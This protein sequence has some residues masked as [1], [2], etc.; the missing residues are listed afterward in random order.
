[1]IRAFGGRWIGALLIAVSTLVAPVRPVLAATVVGRLAEPGVVWVSDPAAVHPIAAEMRNVG[2]T[3]V[4]S[5]VA[6]PVGST[7]RFPNDDP[8]FHSIY[9]ASEG[10]RVRHRLLSCG[11]GQR[12]GLR[13]CRRARCALPHSRP[14]ARKRR[15]RRRSICRRR[16]DLRARQ[17]R[18]GRSRHTCLEFLRRECDSGR[19]VCPR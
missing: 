13:P 5:L 4:P 14:D 2:K 15:R 12:R 19:Y 17:Y 3:F 9:S 16:E 1:M 6:V 7:I 11:A 10:K 18:A 8:F